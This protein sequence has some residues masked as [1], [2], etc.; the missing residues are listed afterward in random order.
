MISII[1]PTYNRA[2]V[3][4]RTLD[5][6]CGQSY[7]DWECII[8][9]DHS[10]DNTKDIVDDYLR[11]DKRF[12]YCMNHRKKG[13]QGARN[14]GVLHA[15]GD[16]VL[17]FDSDDVM[18]TDY[19]EKM[20]PLM[21]SSNNM[22]SCY[23]RMIEEE[24]G[25][26]LGIMDRLK[27][28]RVF[29]ELLQGDCYFTYQAT[30]I[31]KKCLEAIGYLDEK[32]PSHQEWD[33]HLRLSRLYEYQVIPEVLWDYYVGRGDTISVNKE[34]HVSGLL[35][36][37]TKNIFYYRTV[38]YRSLLKKTRMLWEECAA[39]NGLNNRNITRF[40]I[41]MLVP[42]L[43]LVLGVRRVKKWTNHFGK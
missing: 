35:Y 37:M 8:V 9:D 13:A 15:K 25:K 6:V 3:I 28:G 17:L 32:C 31:R 4:S 43:S 38:A 10:T 14:E 36:V 20:E 22:I 42:E 23:G 12:M 34:K 19:L 30:L 40:K 5:S 39:E 27:G 24:S 2:F 18:H 26:E 21:T 16:W 29:K 41:M 7:S 11:R 33:T 1:I